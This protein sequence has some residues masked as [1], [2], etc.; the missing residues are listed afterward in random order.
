MTHQEIIIALMVAAQLFNLFVLRLA[1]KR[2]NFWHNRWTRDW[3]DNLVD[4]A[5]LMAWRENA[6]LRDPKTGR[7]IKNGKI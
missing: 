6:V 7:F 3:S 4:R 1:I 2:A 5:E